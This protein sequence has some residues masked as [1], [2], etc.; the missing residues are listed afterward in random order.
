MNNDKIVII[1]RKKHWHSCLITHNQSVNFGHL[2][3]YKLSWNSSE[4]TT[5]VV[6]CLVHMAMSTLP[7]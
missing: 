5:Q 7:L 2:A 6:V 3:N 1:I 4:E